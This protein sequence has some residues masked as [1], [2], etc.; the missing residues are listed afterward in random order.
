MVDL[1]VAA[2][3]SLASDGPRGPGNP[4][5]PVPARHDAIKKVLRFMV[6]AVSGRGTPEYIGKH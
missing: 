6:G 4:F 3:L 2:E 1:A 5:M